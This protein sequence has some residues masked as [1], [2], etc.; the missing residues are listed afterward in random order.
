[1]PQLSDPIIPVLAPFRPL[2][3]A[4]TWPR[5]LLLVHGTL[6]VRG[7]RTVAAALRVMGHAA[8]PHWTRF[9]QV[10]NRAAWSSLAVSHVLLLLL[11]ATFLAPDA[12]IEVAID[13]HLERRWGPRIVQRG[14]YRDP[15]LSG[16]GLSVSTSGLRWIC[17][18]LLVPLPWTTSLWA[19]PFLTLLTTPP[20]ADTAAGRR[21][22][23]IPIWAQQVMIL[24]RRWLPTRAITL[25][26]D[27]HYSSIDLGTTGVR[28]R[29]RLL[30]PLRLDA[31]LFAPPAPRAPGQLGAPRVKGLALP[32][33]AV[34]LHDP[35]TVW[36]RG[37]L[38][39]YAQGTYEL[40]WCS[41]QALW[42]HGGKAPLPLRWVLTRDPAGT[43]PARAFLQTELSRG[44]ISAL[45]AAAPAASAPP[46]EP[47]GAA[48]LIL[49]ADGAA[50][51]EVLV[52]YEGRW[53]VEVTLEESRAHLG[54]ETQRQWSRLA[55]LRSTPGLLGLFSLV[56]LCG[57]AL[58][59]DG[60]I[61]VAQAAWYRKRQATFSDV[62]A[63]VR[64]H[65]WRGELLDRPPQGAEQITLRYT[66]LARVMQAAAA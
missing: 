27:S 7:R 16:K 34:L 51:R 5:A 30:T 36:T 17:C 21:H 57:Q 14:H 25:L 42:Y 59:P 35:T 38:P 2:C 15:L 53:R 50:G 9:H 66:D 54:V 20:A 48:G 11:V 47:A 23:T 45:P 13:E 52:R 6:L 19:L 63:T 49:G 33:L 64:R 26:G 60:A 46:G 29:V 58:H 41:G 22:K 40:E 65:L 8:D 10:L 43:H 18:M 28:Q 61:P 44:A 62:L 56:V 24:L 1:M 12:L 31:N 37:A 39:W 55:I 32:K 3:A 4:R